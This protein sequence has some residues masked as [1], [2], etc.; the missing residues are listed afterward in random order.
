[1]PWKLMGFVALLVFATIFIGFNL[2][3]R[4]D[5]SIGFTTFKDVPIFLSLL[6]A[7]ALGVLVM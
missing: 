3:H 1:M 5:V 6:I 7:F 2:E 4:C